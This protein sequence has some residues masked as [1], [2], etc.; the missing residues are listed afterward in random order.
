MGPL[1]GN[2]QLL[3]LGNLGLGFLLLALLPLLLQQLPLA[4][5]L[6]SLFKEDVK[7]PAPVPACVRKVLLPSWAALRLVTRESRQPIV[8]CCMTTAGLFK[9][10]FD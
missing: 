7:Y 3:K 10:M 6:D 2:C 1:V 4:L 9:N 8:T 5:L